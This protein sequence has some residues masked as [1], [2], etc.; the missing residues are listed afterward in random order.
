MENLFAGIH[1]LIDRSLQTG[2]RVKLESGQ[3]GKLQDIG[4]RN[5]K[6][7]TKDGELLVFPN[8]RL[9]NGIITRMKRAETRP[10]EPVR[11]TPEERAG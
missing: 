9:S 3:E 10:L 7:V 11:E 4:W 1:L 6:L 2:D 5:S 8:T